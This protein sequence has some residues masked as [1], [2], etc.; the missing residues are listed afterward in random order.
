MNKPLLFFLKLQQWPIVE[1]LRLEEALL[2]ADT[3]NWCLINEG[4][5]SPSIVLG[6]S[7]IP[8]QLICPKNYA[9]KPISII[10][11]FSGGGT[12]VV[13]EETLFVTFICNTH[14]T[15]VPC[16]PKQLLDWT[17]KFYRPTLHRANFS[18][19]ENDYVLGELKCGG[20]AQY[21]RKERWLHHSTLLWDYDAELMNTLLIPPKMPNY[22]QNRPHLNF[23]CKIKDYL[24]SKKELEEGIKE[25]LRQN[26]D[27]QQ[28][29][30]EQAFS[31]IQRPHR[32]ATMV[33]DKFL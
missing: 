2:R 27:L 28:A 19:R 23:L 26:F 15:G 24:N 10:R 11:R 17:E 1:Q 14:E 20:N 18:I 12:V 5:S 33:L 4:S 21:F 9:R 30:V 3:R 29:S 13:D 7:G 32:K 6:I 25:T 22:R 16:Y 8:E 31:V